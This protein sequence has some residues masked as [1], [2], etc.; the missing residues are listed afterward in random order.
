[1]EKPLPPAKR[2]G[3]GVG[4]WKEKSIV[5]CSWRAPLVSDLKQTASCRRTLLERPSHEV[6]VCGSPPRRE[7]ERFTF[8]SSPRVLS[9]RL[10]L[11]LPAPQDLGKLAQDA[12][13]HARGS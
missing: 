11:F 12:L 8:R 5:D 10:I 2:N 6:P 4:P 13:G 9:I 1:M 3:G 7:L